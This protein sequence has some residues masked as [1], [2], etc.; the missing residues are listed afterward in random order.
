MNKQFIFK[1]IYLLWLIPLAALG[2]ACAVFE[3]EILYFI[4]N[5]IRTS[6][7]DAF[8]S[9]ITLLGELAICWFAWAIVLLFFK[10]YRKNAVVLMIGILIGALIGNLILKHAVARPRPCWIDGSA[11]LLIENPS[12]FSFPSGHTLS[13]VIAAVILTLTDK[14][15]GYF[16]VPLALIQSFSR[17]YLFV[18]FPTDIFAGLILG[19]LIGF[20]TYILSNY[21]LKKKF[22]SSL[23]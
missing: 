14:R 7:F 8:F 18:H 2:V 4:Q 22:N 19:L 1:P 17:L 15:F 13:S 6:F 21:I 16:A 11:S 10:K 12:D 5:N 3:W 20:A 9:K 23:L